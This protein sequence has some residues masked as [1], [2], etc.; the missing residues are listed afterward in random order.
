MTSKHPEQLNN[1]Y[2]LKKI[3]VIWALSAI[4]MGVLA[5]VITPGVVGITSW[6]PLIVYWIS[7]GG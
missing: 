6:P 5:L 4:P 1:Q 7:I 3:L 2:S